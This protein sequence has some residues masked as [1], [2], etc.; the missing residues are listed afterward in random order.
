M[1]GG[2]RARPIRDGEGVV[3]ELLELRRA[4]D[5]R[6]QA[7]TNLGVA[8]DPNTGNL[9]ITG[10]LGSAGAIGP[11]PVNGDVNGN[12]ALRSLTAALALYGLVVDNTIDNGISGA[13]GVVIRQMDGTAVNPDTSAVAIRTV[14]GGTPPDAAIVALDFAGSSTPTPV[15]VQTF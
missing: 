6:R 13:T 15:S 8:I 3:G 7:S 11:V 12:S 2:Y 5:A 14:D 4:S 10:I 1:A 9:Q